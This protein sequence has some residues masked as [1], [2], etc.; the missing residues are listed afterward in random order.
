MP[1]RDDQRRFGA[2]PEPAADPD[3]LGQRV[4]ELEAELEAAREEVR[5]AHDR[6]VRERADLDNQK[7]RATR[8]RQDAVRFGN[9]ALVR[10]LLPVV[11]NLE[12]AIAAA[13]GGG[14]GKPLVDGVELVLKAFLDALQR[15]GVERVAATGERFDPARHEAVAY[16]ESSTHDA[17]HVVEEHQPGYR[18]NDRLLRPAMVTVSK[19]RPGTPTLANEEGGG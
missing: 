17:Q 12:R 19:G 15:H 13:G 10:D 9:E 8:E 16:V 7:K 14:N 5:Q 1:D 4:A 11:D 6:W 3:V 2:V 18:L